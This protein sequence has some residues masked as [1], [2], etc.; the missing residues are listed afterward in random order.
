MIYSFF[1]VYGLLIFASINFVDFKT[2]PW[3]EVDDSGYY[4]ES[5]FMN[6]GQ[7]LFGPIFVTTFCTNFLS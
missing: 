6:F 1:L 2:E 7:K 5:I 3:P 4:Q